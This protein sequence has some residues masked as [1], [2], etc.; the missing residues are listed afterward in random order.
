GAGGWTDIA[1]ATWPH[2]SS[3]RIEP[4]D[5]IRVV[6]T[7]DD[8]G[9]SGAP[10]V[11]QVQVLG[12]PELTWVGIDPF[13]GTPVDPQ[14]GQADD[15][16]TFKVRYQGAAPE[17]VRLHLFRNGVEVMGSPC[18]MNPGGG[19]L[20]RGLVFWFKRR[21]AAGAY[22]CYFS[23]SD[24][25]DD[26]TGDPTEPYDGPCAGNLGPRL[27][28]AG[29]GEWTDDPVDPQGVQEPGTEF[30]WKIK[31]SDPEANPAQYVRVHIALRTSGEAADPIDTEIEGSPFDMTAEEGGDAASGIVY[32]FSRALEDEGRYVCWFSALEQVA[33]GMAAQEATGPPTWWRRNLIWLY[34]RPPQLAWSDQ[35][36][37]AD[38]EQG[39]AVVP[40]T[41]RTGDTFTFH[42]QYQ[43]PDSIEPQ[44]VR[45][46]LLRWDGT[47]YVEVP[48]SPYQM[49]P[50]GDDFCDCHCCCEVRIDE[51]G[52][53]RYRFSACDGGKEAVGEPTWHRMPGPLVLG[54]HPPELS[55]L[56]SYGYEGD[57]V[58]RDPASP[59]DTFT[60]AVVYSDQDADPA[61]Y[62]R[63]HIAAVAGGV[64]TEL[65]GSPFDMT[66]QGDSWLTGVQFRYTRRLTEPGLY[67][68]WFEASDGMDAAVGP[69]AERHMIGPRMSEDVGSTPLAVTSAV[70]GATG[71]GGAQVTFTVSARGC[72]T[73]E[74]L[75]IA[76][77]RV[78]LL[79]SDREMPAGTNTLAWNGR[80]AGGLAAPSGVYLIRLS[81]SGATG[82]RAQAIAPVMVRR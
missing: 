79:V 76:G 1:G 43:H 6:C 36:Q 60:W 44:Y 33:E 74:V 2:L 34:H 41:G 65:P 21:L 45:L 35:V 75:N 4:D 42:S 27:T 20:G 7:P 19:T 73:A 81:V 58:D 12:A 80:N 71:A 38:A 10:V 30:T 54:N 9:A 26:A 39:G 15:W 52:R 62:L 69:P 63:V 40:A 48:D 16:Y 13:V 29:Y 25:Y 56:G 70:A 49:A 28:W 24:G 78:R 66:A 57:G 64:E 46:H 32:G 68:Y 14:Q 51:P 23:A 37:P 53:Y 55:W 72:V 61:Q 50:D 3:A 31:Y 82:A 77:R 59:A 22:T 18:N 5:L 67:G 11:A 17:Y 47:D 8:G